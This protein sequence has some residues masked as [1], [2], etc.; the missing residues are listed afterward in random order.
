MNAI[1]SAASKG[2]KSS[3]TSCSVVTRCI[4]QA[5]NSTEI[6]RNCSNLTLGSEGWLQVGSR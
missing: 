5:L 1:A 6:V 4:L 2:L 3:A